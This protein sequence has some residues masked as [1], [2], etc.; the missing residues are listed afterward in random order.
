[1]ACGGGWDV[2]ALAARN[3]DLA[4]LP[5][6]RLGDAT[7]YALPLAGELIWF[8]CRFDTRS[9]IRVVLPE[10]AS[11]AENA[12]LRLALRA[13]EQALGLRFEEAKPAQI[14]IEFAPDDAEFAAVTEAECRV[15]GIVTNYPARLA[16]LLAARAPR[17]R[18]A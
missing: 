6:Q 16:R 2:D 3:P 12:R 10:N 15:D 5:G 11:E 13:W 8:L 18:T 14:E 17:E 4:A 7:P 1:M 9:P